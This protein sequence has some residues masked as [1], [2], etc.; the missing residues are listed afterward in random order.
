MRSSTCAVGSVVTG[1]MGGYRKQCPTCKRNFTHPPAFTIHWKSCGDEKG[2]AASPRGR[3]SAPKSPRARRPVNPLS[4]PPKPPPATKRQR[5]LA[6][7]EE[8]SVSMDMVQAAYACDLEA[9]SPKPAPAQELTQMDDDA[10]DDD[11]EMARQLQRELNGFRGR[12]PRG[13]A[14]KQPV[15]QRPSKPP[16]SLSPSPSPWANEPAARTLVGRNVCRRAGAKTVTTGTVTQR[17]LRNERLKYQVTYT[18]DRVE[19]LSFDQLQW[20]LEPTG[21]NAGARF[22]SMP[23]DGDGSDT[24]PEEPKEIRVGKEYQCTGIPEMSTTA[25]AG[26]ELSTVGMLVWTPGSVSPDALSSYLNSAADES[27]QSEHD[28]AAATPPTSSLATKAPWKQASVAAREHLLHHL[29]SHAYDI[30]VASSSVH[31]AIPTNGTPQLGEPLRRVFED[32]VEKYGKDFRV[33][34]QIMNTVAY[35]SVKQAQEK[36]KAEVAEV[37]DNVISQVVADQ[38]AHDAGGDDEEPDVAVAEPRQSGELRVGDAVD[39]DRKV[40]TE[41]GGRATIVAKTSE[42]LYVV[43][44]VVGTKEKRPLPA[45]AL[46]LW[47]AETDGVDEDEKLGSKKTPDG[48][49]ESE[50]DEEAPNPAPGG[51]WTPEEDDKLIALIKEHGEVDWPQ[52]ANDLGTGRSAKACQTRYRN[53]LRNKPRVTKTTDYGFTGEAVEP[54]TVGE[55]T[56]WYYTVWKMTPQYKA[57]HERWSNR[58]NSECEVCNRAGRLLHCSACPASYHPRCCSP[59]YESWDLAMAESGEKDT[60]LCQDCRPGPR[61]TRAQ[62]TQAEGRTCALSLDPQPRS[63]LRPAADMAPAGASSES[64]LASSERASWDS[65]S[66]AGLVTPSLTSAPSAP[67]APPQ[68]PQSPPITPATVPVRPSIPPPPDSTSGGSTKRPASISNYAVDLEPAKKRQAQSP[69]STPVLSPRPETAAKWSPEED[70]WLMQSVA[71][72]GVGNWAIKAEEHAHLGLRSASSV[73]HRW[74]KLTSLEPERT[75]E[76]LRLA[77]MRNLRTSCSTSSSS[78]GIASLSSPS[79]ASMLIGA[80]AGASAGFSMPGD[81]AMD[82][83]ISIE[84]VQQHHQSMRTQAASSQT[85]GVYGQQPEALSLCGGVA[86]GHKHPSSFSRSSSGEDRDWS[87]RLSLSTVTP[88]LSNSSSGGSNTA[89]LPSDGLKLLLQLSRLQ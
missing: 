58:N 86:Q 50:S 14:A 75:A 8:L 55:L 47:G 70:E 4:V 10:Q 3:S 49:D 69:E 59:K 23:G 37:L 2:G 51:S 1:P 79:N 87:R 85:A 60:W 16:P 9:L 28:V 62:T 5:Q 81:S 30:S 83:Q 89:P 64:P 13:Q 31:S 82:M 32:A 33:I 57:W 12:S 43:K 6:A 35:K 18:D 65:S 74:Q 41:G 45:A 61:L 72:T 46:S 15:R 38:T 68:A 53:H 66:T 54:I 24:E 29:H 56:L 27:P 11:A 39:V 7:R 19:E 21:K 88:A 78:S 42:G 77:E 25:P 80:A 71:E 67:A 63:R 52:R 73:G 22:M 26:A 48:Q 20:L 34:A 17:L 84:P 44:Y 40:A 36:R 76:I